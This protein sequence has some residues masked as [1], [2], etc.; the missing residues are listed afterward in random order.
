MKFPIFIARRYLFAKKSHNAINIIT[1]VSVAGVAVGTMA[2]VI[3]L[4]VFNGFERVILNLFNAFNPDIEIRLK[5]GAVFSMDEIPL[6]ELKSIPG[7]ILYSEV[8]DESAL[9]T[10][11]NRQHLVTMRGVQYHYATITGIDTMLVAGD[12]VLDKGDA[13]FFVIG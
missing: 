9:I 5:E 6:Q 8:V 1:L 12:F 7:V 11:Q 10:H 13:D 3:V 2:L 4:S